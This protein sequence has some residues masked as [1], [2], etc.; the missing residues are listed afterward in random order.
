ML[1]TISIERNSFAEVHG[2]N[3]IDMTQN[4]MYVR[5]EAARSKPRFGEIAMKLKKDA[6][7]VVERNRKSDLTRPGTATTLC[8]QPSG[9]RLALND[10]GRYLPAADVEDCPGQISRVQPGYREN[11]V[12]WIISIFTTLLFGGASRENRDTRVTPDDIDEP[13]LPH[14]SR[15]GKSYAEYFYPAT[16]SCPGAVLVWRRLGQKIESRFLH[17]FHLA[18]DIFTR[19]WNVIKRAVCKWRWFFPWKFRRTRLVE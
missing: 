4:P 8:I 2:R 17:G 15:S 10:A 18:K 13:A 7:K 11:V 3:F 9:P 1:L 12:V 19:K 16:S 6:E 5:K 14:S